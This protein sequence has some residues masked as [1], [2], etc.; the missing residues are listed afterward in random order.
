MA[1]EIAFESDVTGAQSRAKGSDSRLNTS[2]RTDSRRYYNSRDRGQAYSLPF[3]FNTSAS[4]EYAAY[5]KN[6]STDKTMVVSAIGLNSEVATRWLL[7][8]VT[9]I[10]AGGDAVT[11]KN[12]NFASPNDAAATGMEGASAATGIT[13]LTPVGAPVD[14][15][16]SVA[17]GHEEL[18]LDDTLRLG[19]NDAIALQCLET[20]GGDVAGIIFFYYE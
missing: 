5:L 17:T 9:G 13:G 18:R 7:E 2:S 15:A 14:S 11:P 19:Q 1:Q 20:A 10:A 6:T 12:L 16:W 8:E 3:L 4:T